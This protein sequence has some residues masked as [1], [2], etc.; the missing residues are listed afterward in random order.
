MILLSIDPGCE[1]SAWVL[2]NTDSPEP[3][4]NMG[5]Q[6]NEALIRKFFE[7]DFDQGFVDEVVIEMIASYGMAV[8]ASVFETCVMIGR[9]VQ[10]FNKLPVSMMYRKDVK[11]HLCQSM[12][13][14]DAN[15]RQALLDRLG[16]QGTKRQPGP[17]FGVSKDIWSALAVAVTFADTRPK[18]EPDGR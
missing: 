16:P 18:G 6:E 2:Y 4:I 5:I 11:M 8:G 7:E 17:T 3:I 13:A 9:L 1:K 12:R 15:I 10:L 14:K